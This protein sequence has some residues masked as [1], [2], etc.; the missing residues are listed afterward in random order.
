MSDNS[1][2]IFGGDSGPQS[3]LKLAQKVSK[4]E[5]KSWYI[6]YRD[7]DNTVERNGEADNGFEFYG[8]VQWGAHEIF[9]ML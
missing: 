7:S 5:V 3:I 4:G 9:E 2:P 6:I 8:M 1:I